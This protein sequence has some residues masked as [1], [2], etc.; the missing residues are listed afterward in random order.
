MG[1]NRHDN[2]QL[3]SLESGPLLGP[4][5]VLGDAN[6]LQDISPR[7]ARPENQPFPV[8]LVNFALSFRLLFRISE[9]ARGDE[10]VRGPCS[11]PV[12]SVDW[13]KS[14]SNRSG[15]QSGL[16][17]PGKRVMWL[18]ISCF[19]SGGILEKLLLAVLLVCWSDRIAAA[20]DVTINVM[21]G[22]G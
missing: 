13:R 8:L 14:G 11:V 12:E 10:R 7:S 9:P 6:L 3:L 22:C 18:S 17:S 16:D 5:V 20:A 4:R 19:R 1:D 21:Q 2:W 15:A